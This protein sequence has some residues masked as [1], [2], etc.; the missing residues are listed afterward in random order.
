MLNIC[1]QYAQLK[2][3]L[4]FIFFISML[5]GIDY[6]AFH[7]L[8]KSLPLSCFICCPIVIYFLCSP[9]WPETCYIDQV[10]LDLRDLPAPVSQV[11]EL[12]AW[13]TPTR[14]KL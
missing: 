6:R 11:L 13:T 14:L 4:C 2:I 3:I 12:K 1:A 7:M 9:G 8:G 10:G 5:L